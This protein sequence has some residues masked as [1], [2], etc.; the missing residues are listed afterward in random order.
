MRGLLFQL[1]RH[2]LRW[3]PLALDVEQNAGATIPNCLRN[4]RTQCVRG[5]NGNAIDLDDHVGAA[6]LLAGIARRI[7]AANDDALDRGIDADV[8]RDLRRERHYG[9][10]KLVGNR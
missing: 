5:R 8:L 9:E 6:Q 3:K 10:T 7:G 4:H 1:D 2:E